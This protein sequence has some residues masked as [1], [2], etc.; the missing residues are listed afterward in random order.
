MPLQQPSTTNA[1]VPRRKKKIDAEPPLPKPSTQKQQPASRGRLPTQTS[2][3]TRNKPSIAK[4]DALAHRT[5]DLMQTVTTISRELERLEL[6]EGGRDGAAGAVVGPVASDSGAGA[7]VPVDTTSIESQIRSSDIID[8]AHE[9]ET[10]EAPRTSETTRPAGLPSGNPTPHVRNISSIFVRD[11]P[12]HSVFDFD[13]RPAEEAGGP[14]KDMMTRP[15]GV[16]ASGA[17]AVEDKHGKDAADEPIEAAL[18]MVEAPP[19]NSVK[20]PRNDPLPALQPQSIDTS[21]AVS[22]SQSQPLPQHRTPIPE[23]QK[24]PALPAHAIPLPDPQTST[25]NLQRDLAETKHQIHLMQQLQSHQLGEIDNNAVAYLSRQIGR[26]EAENR[27]L[28]D[29]NRVVGSVNAKHAP[30]TTD[31]VPAR[32]LAEQHHQ[33]PCTHCTTLQQDIHRLRMQESRTQLELR[34]LLEQNAFLRDQH[35]RDKTESRPMYPDKENDLPPPSTPLQ[36][37]RSGEMLK[38]LLALIDIQSTHFRHCVATYRAASPKPTHLTTP[39]TIADR[40]HRLLT[41]LRDISITIASQSDAGELIG[42][43]REVVQMLAI[44]GEMY[45]A[46]FEEGEAGRADVVEMEQRVGEWEGRYERDVEAVRR[47]NGG[48]RERVEDVKRENEGL[49]RKVEGLKKEVEELRDYGQRQTVSSPIPRFAPHDI[50]SDS[51]R[52]I[53]TLSQELTHL[54]TTLAAST[55]AHAAQTHTLESHTRSLEHTLEGYTREKAELAAQI[56]TLESHTRSLEQTVEGS[57]RE[58]ADLSEALDRANRSVR[59]HDA[60]ADHDRIQLRAQIHALETTLSHTHQTH[61]ERISALTA[62]MERLRTEA[63]EAV[64]GEASELVAQVEGMVRA[65]MGVLETWA[66]REEVGLEEVVREGREM[67]KLVGGLT[68]VVEEHIKALQQTHA[69]NAALKSTLHKTQQRLTSHENAWTTK[70]THLQSHLTILQTEHA[71]LESLLVDYEK[72]WEGVCAVGNV[73]DIPGDMIRPGS[74]TKQA[75]DHPYPFL[76]TYTTAF[77]ALTST[78][79]HLRTLQSKL[80]DSSDRIQGLEA[81][82]AGDRERIEALQGVADGQMGRIESMERELRGEK[83]GRRAAEGRVGRIV[84]GWRRLWGPVAVGIVG[85]GE[86]DDV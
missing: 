29:E 13:L 17:D 57:R 19:S 43:C 34:S 15:R 84:E 5:R 66:G 20:D 70:L 69:E 80:H 33:Q 59:T 23:Q 4:E 6:G 81:R 68:G 53:A 42:A 64:F 45:F 63:K 22:L 47:E 38:D 56:H 28:V 14:R 27:R 78:T 44:A 62:E 39:L 35:R 67:G 32:A 58:K 72:Q 60:D 25:T 86:E 73:L 51:A 21:Q 30:V 48:L 36:N 8:A 82:V 16:G 31:D 76:T 12:G 71:E 24:P 41:I 85:G 77:S 1:P 61:T 65:Q 52:L 10:K 83:E 11:Q 18:P 74:P 26:L 54:R 9:G 46:G 49:K 37:A 50:T 7:P 2:T 79:Q 75:H 3:S 40:I 55:A